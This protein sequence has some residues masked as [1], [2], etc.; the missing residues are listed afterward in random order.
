VNNGVVFTVGNGTSAATYRMSGN[1]TDRHNF[2]NGLLI[3]SNAVL[4]GNGTVM[5][6]VTVQSGGTLSP[7]TTVGRLILSNSPSLQGATF[8][9]ISRNGSTLT[10]DQVQAAGLLTYGGSLTVNDLGPTSLVVGDRFQ[11]FTANSYASTFTPLTLP[12]LGAGLSW[13]NK[14]LLDGS[15]EVVMAP[16]SPKFSGVTVVGTNMVISGTGGTPGSDYAILT[17]TNI[18]QPLSNWVSLVTNQFDLSG[19]FSFTN[20]ITPGE[21]QRYFRFRTP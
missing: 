20:G 5:G 17:A 18:V 7:G 11:L 19:N 16:V 9:E 21:L 4:T 15:I 10:N 6:G 8:M 2:A 14:L 12:T 3:A 1:L 13:T